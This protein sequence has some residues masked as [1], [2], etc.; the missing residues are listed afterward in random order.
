MPLSEHEQ[1]LLE[2]MERNLYKN[3]AD[4]V[5]TLGVKRMPNYRAMAIGAIVAIAGLITMLAGVSQGIT[6]VGILGFVLLFAGVMIAVATPG[7]PL[8]NDIA[9]GPKASASGGHKNFMDNL[10][11]RWD[12]RQGGSAN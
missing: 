6:V 11:D 8:E 10:N 7:R 1:R 2:E 9:R 4:V 5:S 12:R 3:E